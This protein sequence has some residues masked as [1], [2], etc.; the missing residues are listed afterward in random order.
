MIMM[1]R[2]GFRVTGYW[3]VFKICQAWAIK[4]FVCEEED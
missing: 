4:G 2:V 1:M 3:Y